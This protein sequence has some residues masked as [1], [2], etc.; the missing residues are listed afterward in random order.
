MTKCDDLCA[1][2]HDHDHHAEF[3]NIKLHLCEK[4]H[5]CHE[6]CNNKGVCQIQYI[7]ETK[8]WEDSIS[9]QE[10]EYIKPLKS[11]KQCNVTIP[12]SSYQHEGNHNCGNQH[13][14]EAKCPEC[15]SFCKEVLNHVGRHKTVTY[16]NKEFCYCVSRTAEGT[17]VEG[18]GSRK[19]A[20]LY[21]P[22]D[23]F[24]LET[25][26]LQCA[27]KGRA[28]Y[29]LIPC[30]KGKNCAALKY[31]DM[32]EHCTDEHFYLN[33]SIIYE[34]YLCEKFWAHHGW[35]M[36]SDDA[37]IKQC[38]TV[39]IHHIQPLSHLF[40][41]KWLGIGLKN[42]ITQKSTIFSATISKL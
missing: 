15:R 2:P 4:E 30:P 29:H 16:R 21:K 9:S 13:T 6:D 14:C 37:K 19:K 31:P 5:Q 28:H 25:C 39:L 7:S 24:M 3:K 8:M 17:K 11:W 10:Y 40:V 33:L 12:A 20:R 42:Q 23:S 38:N 22:G 36:A 18:E 27:R 35:H 1:G 26:G 32:V 41:I 34:K